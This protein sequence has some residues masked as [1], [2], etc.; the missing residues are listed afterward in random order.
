MFHVGNVHLLWHDET[1]RKYIVNDLV[2]SEARGESWSDEIAVKACLMEL[3]VIA[4]DMGPSNFTF[5]TMGL[6]SPPDSADDITQVVTTFPAHHHNKPV[7]ERYASLMGVDIATVKKH[8]DHENE[9]RYHFA[10]VPLP[11]NIDAMIL[12]LKRPVS[13]E[14]Y[15][16]FDRIRTAINTS[17]GGCFHVNAPAGCGKTYVCRTVLA[18]VRSLPHVGL[19][20]AST[21]IASLNYDDGRTG[22]S[23]FGFRIMDIDD[24]LKGRFDSSFLATVLEGKNT[25]RIEF[26]RAAKLIV[27][28]EISMLHR[29]ILEGL[30]MLLRAIMNDPRPFGGK[31]ILTLG[32]WRQ[33]PPVDET[34]S[35][36]KRNES[37]GTSYD[38]PPEMFASSTF[39]ITVKSSPLWKHFTQC[40]LTQ[41]VRAE[42]APDFHHFLMCIGDG[43]I[44]R[45]TRTD[46]ARQGIR[47][48]RSTA[49]ALE[50]LFQTDIPSPFHPP[51]CASRAVL[52]PF[53]D[54]VT[55][56]N[57]M[58]EETLSNVFSTTVRVFKSADQFVSADACPAEPELGMEAPPNDIHIAQ[59][60]RLLA[61]DL[62]DAD[63]ID[64]EDV[65]GD[66]TENVNI[67]TDDDNRITEYNMEILNS[68]NFAGVPPH[69]LHLS[70]GMVVVVLR[71]IDP[72][73]RILN[74]SRFVIHD[75]HPKGRLLTLVRPEDYGK[76]NPDYILLPRI[77]F[78]CRL[79]DR[80]GRLQRKQFP[81]RPAYGL[82]IHKSQ[83]ATMSRAVSDCRLPMQQHGQ[84][85]VAWS[86]VRSPDDL[87]VIMR[88]DQE[89]VS[90]V[91]IRELLENGM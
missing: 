33:I 32:D 36:P 71:N 67:Q 85:Y 41:N 82:T 57:E 86:R 26:I 65:D 15:H 9:I 62:R 30:D 24:I 1:I 52:A 44:E 73:R 49:E 48:L 53:N 27:W 25:D 16:L 81:V 91:V 61:V 40:S 76:E 21:G 3:Y 18:Y 6:P 80:S 29:Y 11:V 35:G 10:H 59:E 38:E 23:M 17:S 58:C 13:D 42:H 28:D 45:I 20:V 7:L 2:S 46:L 43:K 54:Q 14:Q 78:D 55:H 90:N 60:Q 66:F 12:T 39:A 51:T 68:M 19:A 64:A 83:S 70:V 47:I 88:D 31:L 74:G 69:K 22:H 37:E 89:F 87:A 4:H 77:S 79:I 50:W 34:A 75:I 5:A 84:L 63:N 56:T 72:K 8:S